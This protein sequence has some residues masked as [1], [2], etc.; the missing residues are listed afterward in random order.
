MVRADAYALRTF[1]RSSSSWSARSR[2]GLALLAA[3][4]TLSFVLAIVGGSFRLLARAVVPL[5]LLFILAACGGSTAGKEDST[6][7]VQ[8]PGFTFS[9]PAAWRTAR[10]PAA[11]HVSRGGKRVSVLVYPLR[12]TYRPSLFA[13]VS[14]ELDR[15]AAQLAAK[16]GS[17]LSSS[18]TT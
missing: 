5:A 14:R 3:S 2:Y 12:A 13:A 8:G 4:E 7:V 11:V 16:D 17:K 1:V 10:G 18:E 15:A 6:R 9:A